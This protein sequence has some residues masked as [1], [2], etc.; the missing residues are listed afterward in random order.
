MI[1]TRLSNFEGLKACS[2][3]SHANDRL[4][5]LILKYEVKWISP[6]LELKKLAA[7]LGA[8]PGVRGGRLP[9]ASGHSGAGA[10]FASRSLHSRHDRA[11]PLER[12]GR[13]SRGGN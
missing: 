12:I 6:L 13:V 2:F 1:K 7:G 8:L 5:I 3:F 10:A 11:V 4:G 9:S